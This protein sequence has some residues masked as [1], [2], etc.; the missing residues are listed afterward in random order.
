MDLTVSFSDLWPFWGPLLW[1]LS[2]NVYGS[3]RWYGSPPFLY[4]KLSRKRAL[5]P[6][7]PVPAC[8][9]SEDG[10]GRKSPSLGIRAPR[11]WTPLLIN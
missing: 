7:T 6:H 4:G 3:S 9:L 8:Q 1:F 5:P 10:K 2:Q 11:F